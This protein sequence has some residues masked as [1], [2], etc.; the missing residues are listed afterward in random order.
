[1][2]HPSTYGTVS[3]KGFSLV[4]MLVAL[5]IVVIVATIAMPVYSSMQTGAKA[6]VATQIQTELNNTYVNWKA[7]GG[8]VAGSGSPANADLLKVLTSVGGAPF[9]SQ[10]DGYASLQDGGMS[11]TIRFSSPAGMDLTSGT[12]VYNTS[13]ANN[14][15]TAGDYTISFNSG[16]NQFY[17]VP[18]SK[19]DGINWV[20]IADATVSTVY[21]ILQHGQP[22]VLA[23][24]Y[25]VPGTPFIIPAQTNLSASQPIVAYDGTNYWKLVPSGAVVA[26]T[27]S[28]VYSVY[29]GQ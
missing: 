13:A 8:V 18:T 12:A 26:G 4:E 2:K 19:F 21:I 6:E 22:L 10:H 7:S 16:S 15:V 17:V 28:L 29:K 25:T 9:I 20:D 23:N 3:Q 11:S 14:P 24:D 1:M 27:P 5:C